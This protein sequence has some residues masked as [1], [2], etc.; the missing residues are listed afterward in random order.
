MT[1]Y[2]HD[3]ILE[4]AKTL[5]YKIAIRTAFANSLIVTAQNNHDDSFYRN[6]KGYSDL[7]IFLAQHYLEN[8]EIKRA[9]SLIEIGFRLSKAEKIKLA[10][11]LGRTGPHTIVTIENM[12]RNYLIDESL[13]MFNP[14]SKN[15]QELANSLKI[16]DLAKNYFKSTSENR[17]EAEIESIIEGSLP[18]QNSSTRVLVTYY[19]FCKSI[20]K[21]IEETGESFLK[22]EK[23]KLRIVE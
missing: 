15:Q 18:L 20:K 21:Q 4:L 16:L 10:A 12:V 23:P 7:R 1:T 17:F 5:D 13:H 6:F 14:K 8:I 11:N 19:T 3:E 9:S 22:H 2:E